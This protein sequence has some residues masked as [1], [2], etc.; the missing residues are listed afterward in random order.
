[1]THLGKLPPHCLAATL[2]LQLPSPKW[3]LKM[4]PKLP[5]PRKRV[6]FLFFFFQT[7]P[8]PVRVTARQL[9][10]KN[11]LAAIFVS[12]HQDAPPGPHGDVRRN[13]SRSAS[14]PKRPLIGPQKARVS[15]EKARFSRANSPRFSL[16]QACEISLVHVL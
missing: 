6:F 2:N 14:A 8:P 10:S 1:M 4:P 5:L 3:S 12:R 11:C 13:W 16:N 9:S 7:P 15:L